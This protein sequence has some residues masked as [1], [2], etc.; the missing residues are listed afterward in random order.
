[1]KLLLAKVKNASGRIGI[2]NIFRLNIHYRIHIQ[3]LFQNA[4]TL[5]AILSTDGVLGFRGEMSL[6]FYSLGPPRA[7]FFLVGPPCG[8]Q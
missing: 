4:T 8:T 6:D 1:M 3:G 7:T 2:F 5:I